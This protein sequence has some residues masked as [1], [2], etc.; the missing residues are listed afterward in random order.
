MPR[1]RVWRITAIHS[2]VLAAIA[3]AVGL[4]PYPTAVVAI[5]QNTTQVDFRR[6]IQP[7]FAERCIEC[8]GPTEQMGGLRLDQRSSALQ[9]SQ[10]RIVPGSSTYSLVYQRLLHDRLGPQMP[11]TGAL[12]PEQ[13]TLVKDW[14]DQGAEWPD[15]LAND[16]PAPT[17]VAS[18]TALIEALRTSNRATFRRLATRGSAAIS[19]KGPGGSTALMHAALHADLEAMRV[20]LDRGADPNAS[21]DAGAT[22][23]MWAVHNLPA[24]RMLL[25]RGAEVNAR[26]PRGQNALTIAAGRSGA[27]AV[28]ALL[29]ERGARPAGAALVAAANANDSEVFQLLVAHGADV[30]SVAPR[31]LTVA[32][33]AK[34][35]S[36][37]DLVIDLVDRAGLETTLLMLAPFGE[38]RVLSALLARGANV[39]AVMANAR[40]DIAGRTPLMLAAAS[41]FVPVDAVRL[42]I[43]RGADVH[44]KGPLGETALDLARRN[45]H[46]PV[47][48]LLLQAG[49]TEAGAFPTPPLRP[50][51][52][53]AVSAA[54]E[55]VVPVLQSSGGTFIEKTGCVSCH[56]NTMTA[57]AIAVVRAKRLPVD[58]MAARNQRTR[59][60]SLLESQRDVVRMGGTFT[61]N[62]ASNVLA[63]LAAEK[64]P[65]DETTD[66]FAYFLRTRQLADGRWRNFS[67]D[68]RPPIQGS[69]VEVTATAIRALRVY[70]PA[71]HRAD[72]QKAVERAVVW[73]R[74]ASPRT[75]DER[76]MQLL[77]L[78]WAGVSP[79]NDVILRAGNALKGEQRA[80]GGWAQLSTLGSDPY[81]TGQALVALHAA[82][83][84]RVSDAAYARGV[85]F[86][87][88]TQLEDGSWYVKTRALPFQPYFESG[89]P[90]GPDQWISIAATNWAV[91]AL[92]NTIP[93]DKTARTQS[94]ASPTE[95]FR[96]CSDCPEMVTIPAGEFIMGSDV[97]ESGR[98]DREGPQRRVRVPKI[99]AGKLEVTRAQW[100]AFAAATKRAVTDGC[101]WTGRSGSVIDPIGSWRDVGFHQ[102]GN[103]PAVCISWYDAQEYAHWLSQRTGRKYRLLSEAEWEYAA[104]AGSSTTP[105]P[106]GDTASHEYG[107]YG[108]DVCC[109]GAASGRDRWVNTAPAGSFPANQF[110]LHD[111]HGNV[112]EWV[113]DCFASGYA[114]HPTDGSA[115]ETVVALKMTGRFASMN[116]ASSCAYR[117]LRGGDW[118]NPPA[119]IRSAYRNFGPGPG[120][121]LSDYRSGGVGFRIAAAL[122]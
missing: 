30:K 2:V 22:A 93:D 85:E 10:S 116:G 66:A 88:R 73:L 48:D 96:D 52:A 81:A 63:G 107:N 103:H 86:L 112:L 5:A 8:H 18:A 57:M 99:A 97:A 72:Y 77:G 120:A 108:A 41:D 36:C 11:P 95:V 6:D 1:S 34:C 47:V 113:Q 12:R 92:A 70:A 16:A 37:V 13:T 21:N 29:L 71:A 121:P 23:L 64:H 100:A 17:P 44:A 91:M 42:L 54:I 68:H 45:G 33:R 20:L 62:T 101:V 76:A 119:F 94:G 4:F 84:L 74:R 110:G 59:I 69:D 111:M 53:A 32:M 56:H 83:V 35:E 49:A 117:M 27:K 65:P 19:G 39:N 26:S 79:N 80:D 67:I 98:S 60:V 46:T 105:Y 118:G 9:L 25:E 31:L 15:D 104:R 14:I 28:V 40:P 55:R 24:T 78:V 87:M 51:R 75:T 89:F 109:S 90:H 43:A 58:D 122:K 50:H 106:W 61:T 3:T 114:A 102:D 38:T 82:D 115:Y 7:L